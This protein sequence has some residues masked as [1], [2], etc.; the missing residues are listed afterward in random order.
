MAKIEEASRE[1][2]E[3][4]RGPAALL[5]ILMI[6]SAITFLKTLC[7]TVPGGDSGE[8]ISV[9]KNLGVAHP[10]GYP[11]YIMLAHLMTYLPMGSVAWRVNL[12]SAIF[13]LA[14]GF[15]VFKIVE[16]WLK[17][18]WLA[19]VSA[20]VFMFSPLVWRYSVVA[21]V[22]TLNN[23]FVSLLVYIS[24][25][26]IERPDLRKAYFWIFVLGLACSHHHTILFLAIPIFAYLVYR[27]YRLLLNPKMILICSGLF[28]LGLSPYFYLPLV[29]EKKLMIS[30]GDTSTW[31]G[32][33]THF[34]RAEYGTFKL[35]TGDGSGYNPLLNFRYYFEDLTLQF[36][37]IGL[38]PVGF[39]L[40]AI[41]KSEWRKDP[42]ALMIAIAFLFYLVVFQSMANMDLSNR[43]FY[44]VQS[45]FWMAPNLLLSLVLALGLKEIITRFKDHLAKVKVNLVVPVVAVGFSATQL[46]THFNQED[47]S[48]NTLFYDLG[49]SMLEGLP[50]KAVLFM[51]GDVYVNSMRYLQSVEGFRTDVAAIPFDLLW[52]P[53]MREI[54][55]TNYPQIK[56]PGKVYRYKRT[57]LGEFTL[58][59]F[60]KANNDQSPLFIG[61]LADFETKNLEESFYLLPL[62]FVAQVQKK[63]TPFNFQIYRQALEKFTGF[64]PPQKVEIRDKS[65]EAFVYYNYWDREIEK[66]R[67]VFDQALAAGQ[68]FE[69]LSYGASLLDRLAR[70]FPEAPANVFRNL[71]VAYQYMGRRDPRF[72]NLMVA[73]WKKYL[74]RNPRDDS[75]L[76]VIRRAV[77]NAEAITTTGGDPAQTPKSN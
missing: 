60:F 7:P 20:S 43:L 44:D 10:P 2:N 72:N 19:L 40:W 36:L 26:F 16:N 13:A 53:W 28:V 46:G 68:N 24:I 52:W 64:S 77:Q 45:R 42:R 62:G 66:S 70:D 17:D 15:V 58:H 37:W 41:W 55:E 74:A 23:F 50:S 30:W 57:T 38:I 4:V 59:D 11:L 3:A 18:R 5:W 71:G 32:F 31:S 56:W 63:T 12:L 73:A 39:G 75:Q 61:K 1:A 49:K 51:R 67:V 76:D 33:W 47:Y 48:R 54:V 14:T 8:L 34:L 35:A 6:V 69:M 65:W 22:F 27:E 29:A 9:A 25:K 21:E